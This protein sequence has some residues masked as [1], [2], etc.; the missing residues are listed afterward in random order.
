MTDLEKF[1][2]L[3]KGFG[4]NANV[5]VGDDEQV[6]CLH[7]GSYAWELERLTTSEKLIGYGGFYSDVIFDMQGNFLKQ[8]FLE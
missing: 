8:A 3:Y 1:I 5:V 7:Q 4:I 6:I 2:E